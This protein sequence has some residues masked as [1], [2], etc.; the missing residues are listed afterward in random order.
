MEQNPFMKRGEESRLRLTFPISG[1]LEH[2]SSHELPTVT[3]SYT[4]R[5]LILKFETILE[6]LSQPIHLKWEFVSDVG[7]LRAL[8]CRL[9]TV[10]QSPSRDYLS[11]GDQRW[12][13]PG[14]G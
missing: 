7:S 10:S 1:N 11:R 6:P 14:P 2:Y 5:F 4:F 13:E 12:Y 3:H 8:L 9:V